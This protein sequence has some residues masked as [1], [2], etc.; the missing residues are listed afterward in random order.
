MRERGGGFVSAEGGIDGNWRRL[1]A[2]AVVPL[3]I[4]MAV[5]TVRQAWQGLAAA[6]AGLHFGAD[7]FGTT[8]GWLLAGGGIVGLFSV[9]GVLRWWHFRFR[10]DDAGIEVREGVLHRR[11]MRLAFARV[12]NLRIEQPFYLRPL[13]LVSLHLDGAGSSGSEVVLAAVPRALAERLAERVRERRATAVG[14]ADGGAGTAVAHDGTDGDVAPAARA[15][16][17]ATG[18]PILQRDAIALLRHGLA[19]NYVWLFAGALASFFGTAGGS[20][21]RIRIPAGVVSFVEDLGLPPPV[22]AAGAVLIL[23]LA[24]FLLS[25]AASVVVHHG[26]RLE[27]GEDG[28]WRTSGGLFEKRENRMPAHKIQALVIRQTA[29]GRLLGV[30]EVLFHHAGGGRSTGQEMQAGGRARRFLVP[31]LRTDEV[32]RLVDE[33]FGA[34]SWAALSWQA[35][36]RYYV[37]HHLRYRVLLPLA[38]LALG[39]ALLTLFAASAD[40]APPVPWLAGAALVWALFATWSVH[41]GWRHAAH[42]QRPDLVGVRDGLVGRRILLMRPFKTQWVRLATSPGQRRHG[43]ATLV[44]ALAGRRAVVPHVPLARARSMRDRL[45]TAAVCDPRPWF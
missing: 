42:A 9:A 33:V 36:D 11:A 1:A 43:V 45:V 22:L 41:A 10:F 29:I 44:I 20:G 16:V 35:V 18:R 12:Q 34:G 40:M 13:G 38:G 15:Q 37:R 2:S 26:F 4:R 21:V 27:R 28:I 39:G 19:S 31:G 3:T 5:Q 23:V 8:T 24:I 7:L 14:V 17:R 32:G 25:A 6:L 30:W